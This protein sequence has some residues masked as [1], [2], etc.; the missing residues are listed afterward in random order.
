MKKNILRI[1]YVIGTILIGS[2]AA[3]LINREAIKD[4]TKI[5]FGFDKELVGSLAE[6]KTLVGFDNDEKAI[7]SQAD[8]IG[9]IRSSAVGLDMKLYVYSGDT[10][11][12][13]RYL[14]SGAVYDA[15]TSKFGSVGYHYIQGHNYSFG[16][17]IDR[18]NNGDKI[19]V[20]IGN[21]T[22]TYSVYLKKI[23]PLD[24]PEF[25]GGLTSADELLMST[26]W[27]LTA[28]ETNDRLWVRAEKV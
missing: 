27:P 14:K 22:F 7:Y 11:V 5:P 2:L 1:T 10:S 19:D 23:A 24:D 28:Q 13:M 25:T 9:S 26:C 15:R 8:I 18:L 20:L 21:K 4:F 17:K 16:V 6:N 3:F 12:A